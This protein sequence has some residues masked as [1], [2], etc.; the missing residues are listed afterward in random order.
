MIHPKG[1]IVDD[2]GSTYIA[3][4]RNMA[5][6][7]ITN[8]RVTDFACGSWGWGSGRVDRPSG[9]AIFSNDFDLVYI[10]ANC[11]L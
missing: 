6:R 4:T 10:G 1:L 11:S 5:I 8:S 9:D 3:V 2:R 7:K